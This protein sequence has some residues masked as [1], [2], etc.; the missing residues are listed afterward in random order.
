MTV[1]MAI[2]VDSRDF[3]CSDEHDNYYAGPGRTDILL[4]PICCS[5]DEFLDWF[6]ITKAGENFCRF[7]DT[8]E[9]SGR[10]TDIGGCGLDLSVGRVLS[11]SYE[12]WLPLYLD[13][14][15]TSA[16]RDINAQYNNAIDRLSP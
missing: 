3:A 4:S 13:S 6:L 1:R 9:L 16:K 12:S 15:V 2:I 11:V 7:A 8:G 5:L 14:L 10:I